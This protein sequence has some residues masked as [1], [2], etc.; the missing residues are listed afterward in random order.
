MSF[1]IAHKNVH[2]LCI[3]CW[4]VSQDTSGT[5]SQRKLKKDDLCLVLSD[6]YNAKE[7]HNSELKEP[8]FFHKVSK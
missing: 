1:Y 2:N 8:W 7:L 5:I 6:Q 3:W 4:W